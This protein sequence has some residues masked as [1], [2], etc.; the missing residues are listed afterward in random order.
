ML[1]KFSQPAAEKATA[2]YITKAGFK[3]P[4]ILQR[5]VIPQILT[6]KELIVE[7]R[8][9]D[10]KTAALLIPII[11]RIETDGAHL[12][13]LILASDTAKVKKIKNLY[14]RF[15]SNLEDPP[16]V[17]ALG[18]EENVKKELRLFSKVPDI[19]VG[20]TSRVIDHIRRE[21]ISIETV[22]LTGID[23]S[24]HVEQGFDQDIHYI[25]SKIPNNQQT[26]LFS[27]IIEREEETTLFDVMK[28]P[29]I[30]SYSEFH[31]AEG[32]HVYF[33]VEKKK[34][35]TDVLC[36]IFHAKELYAC[37]VICKTDTI[38]AGIEKKLNQEGI[39]SRIVTGDLPKDI[40]SGINRDFQFGKFRALITTVGYSTSADVRGI[41]N[42]IYFNPPIKSE[43]YI[44]NISH[45]DR[46]ND[47]YSIISIVDRD[48]LPL[49]TQL[50]ETTNMD[51]KKEEN[52]DEQDVIKG[53]IKK[54]LQTIKEE[55]DP[56]EL[57]YYKKLFKQHVP[58]TMRA[59]VSAYLLKYTL[60]GDKK[61]PS[62]L[63]TMF[64][65]V[66]KNRKVYPKDL[67]RLFSTGL[68]IKRNQI[69]NIKVLDSYSFIDIPEELSEVAINR[70]HGSEFRGRK[71]TVN[72]ARK[73]EEKNQS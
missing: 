65:S 60:H 22:E 72:H 37:L 26:V 64:V 6:G 31:Q 55:E 24:E 1:Q 48:E 46:N 43:T 25:F 38:A 63:K 7:T 19:I 17:I 58:L 52:P 54:V 61:R 41:K 66:G 67:A 35:K 16:N 12:K 34:E 62:K 23:V 71:I 8:N 36:N 45:V 47:S 49:L 15:S 40:R 33:Q 42:I 5:K 29:T 9:C 56:E 32:S 3:Q 14:R 59:Y 53:T 20:T 10:G 44:N 18:L 21:N 28:R 2:E 68:N 73:K 13:A 50:E 30:F 39:A 11:M 69:G 70:L 27:H 57:N 51:I 4:T